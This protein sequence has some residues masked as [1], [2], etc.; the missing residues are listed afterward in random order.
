[1]PGQ[2]SNSQLREILHDKSRQDLNSFQQMSSIAVAASAAA[3]LVCTPRDVLLAQAAATAAAVTTAA[4]V[5]WQQ[6]S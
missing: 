5:V 3:H 2:Q 4:L 1:M 6:H